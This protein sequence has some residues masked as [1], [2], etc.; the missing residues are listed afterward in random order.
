VT[1]LP[2]SLATAL[3]KLA[4]IEPSTD[5]ADF[6]VIGKQNVMRHLRRRG[7]IQDIGEKYKHGDPYAGPKLPKFVLTKLGREVL[8]SLPPA[9]N[10][11]G[12]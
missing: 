4:A 6:A 2:P 3:R 9:E 11:G 5:W 10:G 8:E 7:L 12:S 1:P